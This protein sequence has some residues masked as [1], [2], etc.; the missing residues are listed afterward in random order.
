MVKMSEK[1]HIV[2]KRETWRQLRRFKAEHDLRTFD[3]AIRDLLAHFEL[4]REG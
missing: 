4:E 3:D 2:V 1:A